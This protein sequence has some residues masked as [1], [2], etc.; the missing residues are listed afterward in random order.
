MLSVLASSLLVIEPDQLS[1][2]SSGKLITEVCKD[3]LCH[4]C[5]AEQNVTIS[6]KHDWNQSHQIR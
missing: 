6:K 4:A 3:P 2:S 5:S 1:S